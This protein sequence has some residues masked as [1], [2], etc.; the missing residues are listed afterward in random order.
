[1][2]RVFT[3][4]AAALTIS[5][6]YLCSRPIPSVTA[7]SAD[8]P[9]KIAISA[10]GPRDLLNQYCVTCHNERLLTAGLAL[11]RAD[12]GHPENAPAFW[13]KVAA[14]LR[15]GEMPPKGMP[16]PSAA[17]LEDFVAWLEKTL[18]DAA[19]LK[20]NP[21]RVPVHRL[22]RTEYA[23]AIRD[24][25]SLDIDAR[26]LIVADD[27]DQQ[28]FENIAGVLSV[29]PVLLESYISAA[30]KI[31][32][33][34][35]GDSGMAPAFKTYD[36]SKTLDQ[37]AR[38][39][40]DLP[41]GSRGGIAIRYQF[42]V[43]AEYAMKIRLRRELY[44]YIVGLGRQQ[45]LEVYLGGERIKVFTVG[46]ENHGTPAPAT[47]AGESGL[48]GSPDWE[49]YTHTADAQLEF[50][51]PAKAGTRLVTVSFVG[52]SWEPEGVLHRI[53][54][55]HG[56]ARD[57]IWLGKA[58]VGSVAIGGPYSIVG[59]GESA[60]RQRLFLCRPATL[61]EEEPCADK[62]LSALARRAYR[63]PVTDA[64][65][66]T[67]L[68]FYR[69]GRN[70]GRFETGIQL[71]L[72]RILVDPDFLIRIE[73]PPQGV[74]S[75]TIYRLNDLDLASRLSFFL[76]STIPDEELLRTAEL[77]KLSDPSV[78]EKQVQRMLSDDRA[79]A[80]ISNFASE[81]LDLGKLRGAS[82]DPQAFPEFND[83]LREDFQTETELFL[84]SQ[85]RSDRPVEELLTSNYSFLNEHLARFYGVPNVYGN[86]FR[87]VTLDH[88]QRGGLLGQGSLLVLTSHPTRTSPVTRGK[89]LL[90]NILGSPPP[91]PPP[92]VPALKTEA[93]GERPTSLRAQM[94]AHRKNPACAGC[95]SRMDPL[96]FALENFD[97]I[98]R[99]RTVE[100]GT[101]PIDA[102]AVW[103]DGTVFEG[104]QG[105]KQLMHTHRD[106]FLL[107]FTEKFLTYALGR[108]VEA[109]DMPAVRSI[110]RQASSE[111]YRWSSLVLGI[112]KSTPFQMSIVPNVPETTIAKGDLP[113]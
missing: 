22:N 71:G 14:K 109:Y 74:P 51:F 53:N 100:N 110:M 61:V 37:D 60:S 3:G 24:L 83:T 25:L 104:V 9:T 76:W 101:V 58:A 78:L 13:E 59:K 19:A 49:D 4:L 70:R 57:E 82:P 47:Y 18:D 42:P 66:K 92:D 29:S 65:R 95:H 2:F 80:L 98:G 55:A 28:G 45:Q 11:D 23:N 67:L 91:P 21:G 34:A 30:G 44:D 39:N 112:V 7:Q 35:V 90:E 16:R 6:V 86:R 87:K 26:S 64:D 31:A 73:Q 88:F 107:T 10:S 1:M 56:L 99:W 17:V 108:E 75:G 8:L 79:G 54:S 50:R 103:P 77:G 94:E 105:L 15:A 96:G 5:I 52:E 48:S 89:W 36:V 33:L 32:R 43:D 27:Q 113:Q 102:S 106:Q 63:R 12:I 97:A 38:M 40:E 81:W 41:F 111:N 62:I 93:P 46:G 20:P 68:E 85:L 69:K 84:E 72:R